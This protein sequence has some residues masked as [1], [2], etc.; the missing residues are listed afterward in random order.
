MPTQPL[1]P[2]VYHPLCGRSYYYALISKRYTKEVEG[3]LLKVKVYM[4][5]HCAEEFSDIDILEHEA[6]RP[7]VD[8]TATTPEERKEFIASLFKKDSN[9]KPS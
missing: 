2:K 4:C 6:S 1:T 3:K 7:R 8:I 9:V 5:R